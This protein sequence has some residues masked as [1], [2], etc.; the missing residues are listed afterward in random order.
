MYIYVYI[1]IYIYIFQRSIGIY[2]YMTNVGISRK[3][4]GLRRGPCSKSKIVLYVCE[5]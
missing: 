5:A 3:H 2:I 4:T 1:Y